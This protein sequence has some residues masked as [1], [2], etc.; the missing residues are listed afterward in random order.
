MGTEQLCDCTKE[1]PGRHLCEIGTWV[2]PEK[3]VAFGCASEALDRLG[4]WLYMKPRSTHKVVAA[5]FKQ[6]SFVDDPGKIDLFSEFWNAMCALGFE[7]STDN[8]LRALWLPSL[9]GNETL[10]IPGLDNVKTEQL[11]IICRPGVSVT[12]KPHN[13]QRIFLALE[14]PSIQGQV[15]RV[16]E[17]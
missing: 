16:A 4:E 3:P 9:Y 13:F 5:I 10:A 11:P 2:R 1:C 6:T 8:I 14:A 15:A 7:P 12:S 17:V